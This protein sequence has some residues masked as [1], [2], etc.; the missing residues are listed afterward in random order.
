MPGGTAGGMAARPAPQ[1]AALWGAEFSIYITSGAA[2]DI[3]AAFASH[4]V[5]NQYFDRY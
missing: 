3:G 5:G 4:L 1:P 2:M